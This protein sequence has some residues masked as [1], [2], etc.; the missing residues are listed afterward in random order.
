MASASDMLRAKFWCIFTSL[1]GSSMS[2][3]SAPQKTTSTPLSSTPASSRTAAS[4]A[5]AQAALPTPP[6]KKGK[7]WLPEHSTVK[8]TSWRGLALMS[9]SDRPRGVLTRPSTASFQVSG[10]IVGRSK[11]AM[12][13]NSSFGVIQES[14][15]S[16]T[17]WF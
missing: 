15:S 2:P 17:S 7:P 13:K 5:P 8:A 12:L 4:G 6:V 11:W 3:A 14:R 1:S 16:Q 9:A 10:S